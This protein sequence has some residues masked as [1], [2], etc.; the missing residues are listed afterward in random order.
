MPS[1][2]PGMDPYLENSYYWQGFHNRL[3]ARVADDLAPRLRPHYFVATEVR[4]Y[5]A[6]AMIDPFRGRPDIAVYE[7]GETLVHDIAPLYDMASLPRT[8]I[9]PRDDEV[10]EG[11]LEIRTAGRGKNVVT[12]V[13]LLSPS[14]KRFGSG[15]LAYLQK[16][17]NVLA[18]TTHLVEIDLLRA[19]PTMPMR[20]AMISDYRVLVSRSEHRPRADLYEFSVRQPIPAFLLPLL[21]GSDEPLVDLNRI[22][23]EFYEQAGYDLEIDYRV[24]A[25]PPLS[26]DDAL[27]ADQLLRAAGLRS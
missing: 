7:P 21:P 2:F 14:N 20:D 6:D 22:L 17:G 11:Y 5:V 9:L 19:G 15:R 3:I 26:G 23:H 24:P 18:S 1:P 27:W 16:R 25:E 12:V 10:R 13:E 8:I 4:V